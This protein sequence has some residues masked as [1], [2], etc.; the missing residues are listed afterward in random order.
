GAHSAGGR[1]TALP[2]MDVAAGCAG[3]GYALQMAAACIK[4]GLH[5]RI[6]VV[7][8]DCLTR[9]T[10]YADRQ[11]CILFG[12]GAG[13]V[14]VTA[15][16]NEGTPRQ[17]LADVLYTSI[18]A[19][20][21]AAGLIQI[22]AGGSREPASADSVAGARHTLELRGRE[23]FKTA[24]RQMSECIQTAAAAV[25]VS[26]HD[27][28]VIV[29]HQANAR[30]IE[31]VGKQLGVSDDKVVVDIAET[32]NMASASIPVALGRARASGRLLPAEG[33]G[34][35]LVVVVGFGA[36]TTWACQVLSVHPKS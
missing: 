2:A 25:G 20:G 28:D 22:K 31:A 11:S 27:F 18:G 29:P 4:S 10:N 36:G 9:V 35:R 5:R 34:P 15:P 19:D 24:V 12:D 3:F 16:S 6:L 33:A 21:S 1:G 8:A 17:G 13:A 30:I 32:G 7:G 23:V 14:I 26:V